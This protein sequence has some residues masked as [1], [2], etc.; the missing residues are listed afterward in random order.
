MITENGTVKTSVEHSENVYNEL[1]KNL[2]SLGIL[3][4]VC[5]AVIFVLGLV[6]SILEALEETGDWQDATMI[7]VGAVF[8]ALGIFFLVLY[9]NAAKA[10]LKFK[11]VE[12]VEFF[13]DYLIDKEYTDG[14]LTSTNKVYYKWIVRIR[15]TKSYLFL[16]NTRV[17]A[18]AVDKNSLPPNELNTI[19]ALLGR[20]P[21][22]AP[23]QNLQTE[24]SGDKPAEPFEELTDN[25]EE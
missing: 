18:I 4:I 22:P 20:A 12:E 11:R 23:V 2:R 1:N 3:Y 13:G 8:A 19:R 9:K 17:T 5:G 6:V 16:Y 15:E 21:Q 10:A 25:K 24:Q 7:I 14:E